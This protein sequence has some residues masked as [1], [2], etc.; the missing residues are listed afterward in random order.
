MA[1]LSISD[2]ILLADNNPDLRRRLPVLFT[3]PGR[4][5]NGS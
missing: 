3:W 1:L 2:S 5:H 4:T